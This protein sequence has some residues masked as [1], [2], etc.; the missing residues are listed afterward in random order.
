MTTMTTKLPD[1]R[2]IDLNGCQ[3]V[4]I[5]VIQMAD[6]T[7]RIWVNVD[8]MCAFR[9]YNVKNCDLT[10][11]MPTAIKPEDKPAEAS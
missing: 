8:G 7:H 3:Q 2:M 11:N 9:A 4:D 5:Q 6:G 10:H 1:W